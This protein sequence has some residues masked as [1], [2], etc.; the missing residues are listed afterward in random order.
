[1][2]IVIVPNN[3]DP[4][5]QTH[6]DACDRPIRAAADGVAVYEVPGPGGDVGRVR[7]AHHGGPCRAAVERAA[8]GS[9]GP[10]DVR[11]LDAHLATLVLSLGLLPQDLDLALA[12]ELLAAGWVPGPPPGDGPSA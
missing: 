10:P 9:G 3:G 11:P 6:C 2:A 1:M 8:A 12:R 4:L 7:H 5:L